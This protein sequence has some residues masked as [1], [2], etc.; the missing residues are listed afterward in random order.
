ME[1]VDI[2]PSTTRTIA[3]C[4]YSFL[5]ILATIFIQLGLFA[6]GMGDL[7]P[8]SMS[9]ILAVPIAWCS[10]MIFGN[11]IIHSNKSCKWRC[12]LWG[13]LLMIFALLCYDL[14]LLFLLKNIHPGMYQL[15]NG[16][17]DSLLLFLLIAIYSFILIG[18]WLSIL[19]GISAIFLRDHFAPNVLKYSMKLEKNYED[20]QM[21]R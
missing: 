11:R 15:G 9:F 16:L 7:I 5:S 20:K 17:Q 8:L 12:F 10:G 1:K 4:Y 2:K 21:K 6:F 13:V 19:S 18:S 14:L 3:A